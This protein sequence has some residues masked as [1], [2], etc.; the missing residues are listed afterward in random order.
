MLV[1]RDDAILGMEKLALARAGHFAGHLCELS[2]ARA[3]SKIQIGTNVR[4][5]LVLRV[6]L[7]FRSAIPSMKFSTRS[8]VLRR[9]VA[10]GT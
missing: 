6:W 4:L 9:G 10:Q 3:R 1:A 5:E 7:G 2:R 8:R